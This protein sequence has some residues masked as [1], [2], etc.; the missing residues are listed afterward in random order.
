MIEKLVNYILC[1]FLSFTCELT[2]ENVELDHCIDGDTASFKINGEKTNVRFLFVDTPE[3]TNKIEKY[4]KQAS[5]FTCN[6]LKNAD[7]IYLE[8]EEVKY[9]KYDR[10]LAWVFIT[11]NGQDFLLQDLIASEGYVEKFYD[12]GDYKYENQVRL[13]RND[14]YKIFERKGK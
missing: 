14:P 7:Q 8:Y 10:L 2:Q 12:Y 13:N 1:L 11:E 4:G 6:K 3:S 5:E 9:D